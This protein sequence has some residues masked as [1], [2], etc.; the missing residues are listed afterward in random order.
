M[1]AT[2]YSDR[3]PLE[4]IK[5]HSYLLL[6]LAS[7]ITFVVGMMFASKAIH[8]G[9]NPWTGTFYGNL[10]LG[11]TWAG[12]GLLYGDPVPMEMWPKAAAVGALFLSGQLFT[13][14]AYRFGD[15]SVA[16]PIFGIKIL[17]VAIL[18]SLVAG[19]PVANT[20]W[21]AAVIA[22]VGVALV[23]WRPR[24]WVLHERQKRIGRTIVLALAGA[25]AL[26]I[27]DIL[28]LRWSHTA[29]TARFLPVVFTFS[30]CISLSFL[31]WID[32][33][34]KLHR[35]QAAR[36]LFIGSLLMATQAMGMCVSLSVFGDATRVNIVYALRG[37]WA[38]VLAWLL[39]KQFEGGEQHLP[40]AILLSRALGAILLTAAVIAAL[41]T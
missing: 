34:Q 32:R 20:I 38:V 11:I 4:K 5:L 26:S 30:A 16:T 31:P 14:F 1:H 25:M 21:I 27:F 33:W 28:L 37:L 35:L 41:M 12:I 23:Q 6:P 18:S 40:L 2:T 19:V 8:R 13:Y 15:V 7:S 22:T 9:A 3:N 10:F 36:P 17:F 24:K 29:G 39:A